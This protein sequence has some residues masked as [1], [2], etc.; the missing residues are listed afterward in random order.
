MRRTP[1]YASLT[2]KY[3]LHA[4]FPVS[5]KRCGSYVQDL[6]GVMSE[7]EDVFPFLGHLIRSEDSVYEA[8]SV[9]VVSI[10]L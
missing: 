2:P 9:V 7:A 6:V 4:F 8:Y 10:T 1:S 5:Y 3:V